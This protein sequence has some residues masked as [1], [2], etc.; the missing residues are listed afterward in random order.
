MVIDKVAWVHVKDRRL[1]GARS[2]GKDK[3]YLPGGKREPG[4]TDVECLCREITEELSASL[5]R[6]TVAPVR[7]F[8]AQ[9]DGKPEG[10]I[11]QMSCYTAE[12]SG[13]LQANSEIAEIVWLSF[14]DR[15]Q[16][17]AV[18]QVVMDWLLEQGDLD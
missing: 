4:E 7:V 11:V 2:H 8:S 1:L 10:T 15:D 18:T 12:F 16:C 6:E 17:S 14:K 3:Y 9:A 5:R 13:A